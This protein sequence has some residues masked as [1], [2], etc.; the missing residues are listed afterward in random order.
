MTFS[1]IFHLVWLNIIENK[2]KVVLTSIGIIVGS[3]T[4]VLVIAVGRGGRMDVEDQ[5]KN[6]N[7]ASIEISTTST[8][9]GRAGGGGMPGGGGGGGMA[10][11]G[12]GGGAR[13]GGANPG[14]GGMEGGPPMMDFFGSF[15]EVAATLTYEDAEDIQLFISNVSAATI[16]ASTKSD[17]LG[18]NLEEAE[19]HTIAGVKP[20]YAQISNLSLYIG[21]FITSDDEENKAK[22]CVLGYELALK[23]FDTVAEA[24]DSVITINDV[25]FVVSGILQE[26]GT[27]SSGISPDEAVYIPYSAAEKYI[28]SRD[29]S[30]QLTVVAANVSDVEKV[31]ENVKILL[32]ENYPG[33][34]FTISDAGSKMEAAA[35]S[36]ETLSMLLGAVALIV[37][38]VGGIGIMNVLFVSV[39]ERT[40][41]IGILK[42]LGMSRKDVLLEFLLEATMISVF[43]GAAGV[44]LSLG[45]IPIARTF[46][47]RM[48]P[49]FYGYLIAFLFAVATG[50]IFGFYPANK[51]STLVPVEAL[52]H[53]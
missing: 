39:K 6:L 51:A 18:G 5:F 42:A 41:E 7:A 35:K 1:E 30:P 26:M 10:R 46:G 4:I 52:N 11:G 37:F 8:S 19:E 9:S 34:P 38:L 21:D 25:S 36:S 44:A 49:I 33:A 14:G 50:T 43:G 27:V 17:V 23:L 16:S 40:K 12:S 20:E 3:A 22:N 29:A 24:Y 53:E 2:F 47:V 13:T 45:V 32:D 48:E 28:L 15:R 31:S